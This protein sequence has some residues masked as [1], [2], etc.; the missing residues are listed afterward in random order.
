MTSKP[1]RRPKYRTPTISLGRCLVGSLDDVAEV[2][3][4]RQ[5]LEW[6]LRAA[7]EKGQVVAIGHPHAATLQALRE[8]LPR[9]Q[10]LGVQLVL[11]SE[12]VH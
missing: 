6:A 7:R 1:R 11:A 12:L 3:T 9:A 8:V 10:E 2:A 4:V 5:Q